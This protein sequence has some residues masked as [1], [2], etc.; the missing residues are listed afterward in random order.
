MKTTDIE[1]LEQ[2]IEQLIREHLAE[3]TRRAMLAVQRGFAATAKPTGR[4]RRDESTCRASGRRRRVD[5]LEGL[6]ERLAAAVSA[7]P[8]TTMVVLAAEVGATVRELERPAKRLKK[9]GRIRT[10]GER[11]MTR[12]FP[13]PA[14]KSAA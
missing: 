3:C 9:A 13:L 6:A 11:N 7:K 1:R 10:V 12:Y 5:E 2:Q 14:R 4:R 8:G